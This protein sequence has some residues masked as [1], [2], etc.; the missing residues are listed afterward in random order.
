[1]QTQSHPT[2]VPHR[3]L[4]LFRC[5]IQPGTFIRVRLRPATNV[6]INSALPSIRSWRRIAFAVNA[7]MQA[8]EKL[9]SN[10]R[11]LYRE[12]C[13]DQHTGLEIYAI[14][15]AIGRVRTKIFTVD[16][17]HLRNVAYHIL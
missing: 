13:L 12:G 10:F 2:T 8:A 7:C 11:D 15:T 17:I 6:D 4:G 16:Q 14:G 9:L 3:D 5:V 1:M